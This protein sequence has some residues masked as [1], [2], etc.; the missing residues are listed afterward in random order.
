MSAAT[1][2]VGLSVKVL[3]GRPLRQAAAFLE[4]LLSLSGLNWSVPD[5][6]TLCRRQTHLKVQIPYRAASGPL[7]L[8]LD[9]SGPKPAGKGEWQVRKQG[10]SR[11]RQWRKIHIG[12][13]A[14]TL[15]GRAVAI[16]RR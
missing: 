7:H 14:E 3:F 12:I 15:E 6:T 9:S 5:C 10:A 8:L 16:S 13:D 1:I 2:Q 11:R 4:S